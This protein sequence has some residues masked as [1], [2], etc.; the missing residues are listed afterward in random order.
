MRALRG[1]DFRLLWIGQAVSQLGNQFNYVAL[2][3]MVLKLTG[4]SAAMAGVFLAQVLPNA[5]LGWVAGLVVD[6]AD[7]RRLMAACSA[8]RG[9]LVLALPLAYLEHRMAMGLV[10]GVTFAVSSLTL[11]FY[12]AEKT[13]IPEMVDEA[14]LTAANAYAEMTS[15]ASALAGPVLA[16]MLIAAL[17]SPIYALYADVLGFAASTVA[18]L[19][20]RWRPVRRVPNAE[21]GWLREALQGL[22]F[23]ARDPFVRLICVTAAAVNFLV[24]PF[25]VIFP[26]FSERTFAGGAVGFGWLMGG[27]GGGMLLGSLCTPRLS[28]TLSEATIIYGGMAV[29]GVAFA[30]MG[31]APTLPLAVAGAAVAGFCVA[32][33]NAVILTLVQR[34]TPPHLQGRVFATLFAAVSVATP[35]GV[36]LAAPMLD[37]VGPR[38]V[39]L[40]VGALTVAAAATARALLPGGPASGLADAA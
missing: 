4:S 23:L 25:A 14:D 31:A 34:L 33:G 1:R 8:V 24:G 29:V 2:A 38:A 36:A 19:A 21:S 3:W 40:G 22:Q 10:Y 26:V 16:G 15:Q 35:L 6:R 11:V 27:L 5:L 39:L 20:M 17:P 7:R 18:L 13:A 30:S 37:L 32:P 28:A 9:L 12:A